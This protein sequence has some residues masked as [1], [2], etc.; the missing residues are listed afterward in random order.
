MKKENKKPKV[1][2]IMSTYAEKLKYIDQSIRSILNQKFRDFEFI[3]INDNPKRKELEEFLKKYARKDSRI[4]IITNKKNLGAAGSRN[5]GLKIAKGEYIAIMDADDISLK[6]RLEQQIKFLE[7]NSN[8]F[9]VGGGAI[10]INPRGD[11]IGVHSPIKSS[12]LLKLF[13]PLDNFIYH[14]TIMFRNDG[15]NYRRSFKY[16]QDYDL[17]LRSLLLGKSLANIKE[18]L[19]KYRLHGDSITQSKLREQ[20]KFK[21]MS[22]KEFWWKRLFAK[23]TSIKIR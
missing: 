8:I 19:I 7:K 3:I 6:N 18:P 11:M 15:S 10:K 16:S 9:L 5:R 2:V 20:K 14:P 13:L 12:F 22:Q 4:K 17:Y 23:K 21:R 1:S